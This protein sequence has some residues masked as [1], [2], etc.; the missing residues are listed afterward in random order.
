MI[1]AATSKNPLKIINICAFCAKFG[2]YAAT[3]PKQNCNIA[4]IARNPI[5]VFIF[6]RTDASVCNHDKNII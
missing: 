2:E 4:I 5:I 1:V 3:S 6:V